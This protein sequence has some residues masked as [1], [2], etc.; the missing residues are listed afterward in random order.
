[1]LASCGFQNYQ[2]QPL[3]PSD[4]AKRYQ[5]H[6]PYS[7]DFQRYLI[8]QDYPESELPIHAWGLKELT[9]S[10][11]FFNPDLDLA[12]AQWRSAIASQSTASQKPIPAISTKTE[13]HS[14]DS[15]VSPWSLGLSIDV[16]IETGG[17]RQARIDRASSLSEAS[18][19]EI[20]QTA[21]HIR[22]QLSQNWIAFVYSINQSRILEQEL[23]IRE[24]I[25]SMLQKRLSA[26]L[27]S[28]IDLN[29]ARIQLQKTQQQLDTETA[30]V[31][32]LKAALAASAGLSP[33]TLSKLDLKIP[34]LADYSLIDIE[35]S[36]MQD[37]MRDAQA[38]AVLN[39]LDIRAALARYA[40][41]EFK[42]KLEIAKQYP[43]IVL[44][45][46]Y[47][48]DQGDRVWSL[49][50]GALLTFLNK[51]RGPIE[52]AKSLRDVEAAQFEVLQANVINNLNQAIAAF[53]ASQDTLNKSHIL[54]E[55]MQSRSQQIERQF[56][57]GYSDRLELVSNKLENLIAVQGEFDAAYRLIK[58][59]A[60]LEDAMQRPLDD[61]SFNTN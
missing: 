37:M 41:A 59:R 18:K 8:A 36:K 47:T 28:S 49:G 45:P 25:A 19:L 58:A 10:A 29:N 35:Q 12:R 51:N 17:K 42:L 34:S 61:S 56:N 43:D 60:N 3:N 22:N 26:G 7:E 13:N 40:A 44:S 9:F 14:N 33:E 4:S 24:E 23:H 1:M 31:P 15:G 55:S 11:L 32:V 52:E 6:D 38:N 5:A 46:D 16:P 21:W 39:R 27:S 50:I 53:I 2:A 48:Y 20:G 57:A 54:K 30:R